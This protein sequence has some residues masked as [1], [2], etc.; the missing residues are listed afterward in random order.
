MKKIILLFVLAIF[1]FSCGGG[2][3]PKSEPVKS[4]PPT[5]PVQETE[6][7]EPL[8]QTQAQKQE[9]R[10]VPTPTGED[11]KEE[12]SQVQ[13]TKEADGR[14]HRQKE[15][16]IPVIEPQQKPTEI[17]T[18]ESLEI[19][20]ITDKITSGITGISREFGYP[21]DIDVPEN[22]KNRVAYYIRYFTENKEGARFFLRTMSRGSEYL[23]MIKQVLQEKQLPLSLAY[24]PAIES[25]FNPN[26]RSR[27]GAVGMWQFM[28]GTARMYGLKI[29]RSKDERRDPVKS[30]FA[31]AE[32][33]NDLLAMFGMEDPFLGICAFNAGE[34]KILNALRKI[35]FTERSFWTLVNKNLLHSETDEYIPQFI[36]VILMAN[37]PDKYTAAAQSISAEPEEAKTEEEEDRE[38]ISTLHHSDTKDDLGEETSDPPVEKE[39]IELK[40]VEVE[41]KPVQ[42]PTGEKTPAAS[43]SQVYQ[44][45]PGD[46]LYSI[47]KQ[48]NVGVSSLKNWNNLRANHIYP[49][50]KLKIYP[51]G[52]TTRKAKAGRGGY[53]LIYTVNYTDSL[54]RIALFFKGVSTR[55][56]MTWNRLKRTRIYPKQELMLHLKEPPGKVV[57]HI[58]KAG[59]NAFKIAKKYGLRVEYVLSL[60]G[61]LTNSPLK[62]GQ[63]LK[64]YFF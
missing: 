4:T 52:S 46:T 62:P 48:H 9:T 38:V 40:K 11:K 25:G 42:P 7:Q 56:I 17:P 31:A 35:S 23:P 33:L 43:P 1:I 59:E 21:G 18:A 3:K 55:D 53:Q 49:G 34:G 15:E 58:V 20:K 24:L 12:F 50:Q 19:K 14:E 61:L 2:H 44:V 51:A 26:A 30:T 57:T 16:V 45:K 54:A 28:R 39:A 27:A 10:E 60:N 5:N 41:S 36:A 13:E 64:I 47:A 32:Y 29:T 6:T 63:K 8:K 22:F 37:N